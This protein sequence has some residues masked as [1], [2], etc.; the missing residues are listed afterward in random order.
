MGEQLE[1]W[2]GEVGRA[3]QERN[4]Y[5]PRSAVPYFERVAAGRN[6]TSILEVGCNLGSKLGAWLTALPGVSISG[7]EPNAE[8]VAKAA[9]IPGVNKVVQGDAY[10]IPFGDESFDL[11][12]TS[13]VL[14]H[15]PTE[16]IDEAAKEIVR[17]AKRYVLAIEQRSVG[18][19]EIQPKFR[20]IPHM[21]FSRDYTKLYGKFDE[22]A[23]LYRESY[24]EWYLD[25]TYV[26]LFGK[27]GAK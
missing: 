11:V 17:V 8:A 2:R 22:L 9:A 13:G 15:V 12:F 21:W 7:V 16:R 4:P 3:Y 10:K 24:R 25:E 14:M 6:I 27:N 23:F 18:E 5:E 20:G 26:W 19:Q 1:Q